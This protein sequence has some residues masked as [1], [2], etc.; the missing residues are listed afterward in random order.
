[1]FYS[2]ARI[3]FIRSTVLGLEQIYDG[4]K[5]NAERAKNDPEFAKRQLERAEADYYG[6]YVPS[7]WNVTQ[8]VIETNSNET[9]QQKSKDSF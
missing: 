3:C 7:K 6:R 1:M 2:S 5:K 4:I 8:L 9:I